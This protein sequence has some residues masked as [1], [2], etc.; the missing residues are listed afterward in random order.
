MNSS[1]LAYKSIIAFS[2]VRFKLKVIIHY[3]LIHNFCSVSNLKMGHFEYYLN[4]L[5]SELKT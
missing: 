3:Y 1:P 2:F 4:A 5:E